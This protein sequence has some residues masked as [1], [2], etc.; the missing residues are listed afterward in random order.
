MKDLPI[1]KYNDL[2]EIMCLDHNNHLNGVVVDDASLDVML[3]VEKTMSRLDVMGDD[4]RRELW[5]E[6][7]A[8]CKR[9][10]EEDADENGNYWYLLITGCYQQMHYM[11]LSNKEWRFIDLRSHE[12]GCGER[13]PDLWN[14]NVSKALKKLETYITALVDRICANP[15]EYNEYVAE[16]LP[17]YKREGRIRRKDLNRIC[18][19]Y[20]TFE[21]PERVI[22]IVNGMK[23]LPIS[24]YDEMTLRTYM[25]VW[26]ILY[27]AYCRKDRYA[28]RKEDC[29]EGVSD[30]EVFSHNS[31]GREIEGFDLDSEADF[32]KWKNEN[33][34]Y[35]CLDVAYARVHLCPIKSGDYIY[36]EELGVPEGKWCFS[37]GYSVYGY[38]Q[39]VVNMLEAMLEAG[40][41]LCCSSNER[42]LKIALEEDWVSISP[43]P[44]K[45]THSEE[46]GNEI[47]LPY[48]DDDITEEQVRKVIAATQW[49][50]L[51]KVRLD[52]LIPLDDRVYDFMREEVVEPLTMS[53]I[54]HKYEQKYKTNLCVH[55]ESSKGYFFLEK[56]ANRRYVKY[57]YPTFNEAMRELII[58][59]AGMRECN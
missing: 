7:K 29:F 59:G 20:K 5:I 37:L 42:L 52:K 50:P 4:E 53:D 47:S 19:C 28:D 41:G 39:D 40:I 34:S 13:K 15:E 24:T 12:S 33:S 44:N 36:D 32:L 2:I 58:S 1:L 6:L 54:R 23:A 48:I 38:S 17:Y 18:P 16:H 35:H 9:D 51:E 57:Y 14:G 43:L 11:I 26:R 49:E 27:E 46:L 3:R 25:H 10:R 22:S 56:N 8:P 31:K 55:Y 45:Y 21:D 30:V